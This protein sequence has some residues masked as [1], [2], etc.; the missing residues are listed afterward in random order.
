M[1]TSST[2]RG[3]APTSSSSRDGTFRNDTDL[4]GA[5]AADLK[6]KAV[7]FDLENDGDADLFVGKYG[8]FG[9]PSL[10]VLL[11]REGARFVDATFEAGVVDLSESFD[12]AT[13]DVDGDGYL[14][15]YVVNGYD[16][17]IL[18]R[19]QGDGTFEDVTASS[20]TSGGAGVNTQSAAFVDVDRDGD[21]DLFVSAAELSGSAR[22]N[23]LFINQ[24]GGTFQEE[25]Q[26]RGVHKPGDAFNAS[27]GDIDNDG[28][29]DLWVAS[30]H[31]GALY[32]NDGAGFFSDVTAA[33][34]LSGV[35]ISSG[36]S[37]GDLDNDGRL[38]LIVADYGGG[39][40]LFMNEGG[41][42]ADRSPPQRGGPIRPVPTAGADRVSI[43]MDGWTSSSPTTTREIGSTATAAPAVTGSS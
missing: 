8:R 28:D 42:F 43:S 7:V 31:G 3:A 27:F 20:G 6:A 4:L 25:G 33:W 26:L 16:D 2:S 17:N 22:G 11:R 19:N 41:T 5:G 21:L 14:D 39:V 15:L 1:S 18:Y 35:T 40:A 29:F 36:C 12:V 23:L 24:G 34:G 37:F 9:A 32:E 38:D 30:G 13:G 10:N